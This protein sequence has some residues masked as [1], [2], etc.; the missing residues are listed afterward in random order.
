MSLLLSGMWEGINVVEDVGGFVDGEGGSED[1]G[2]ASARHGREQGEI[3]H[4]FE[5]V[6]LRFA[7][8]VVQVRTHLAC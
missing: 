7:E 6:G 5:H 3:P 2:L 8:S 4:L 1:G